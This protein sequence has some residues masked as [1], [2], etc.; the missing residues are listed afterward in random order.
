MKEVNQTQIVPFTT[1]QMYNLVNDIEQYPAFLPWCGGASIVRCSPEEIEATI[2]ISKG[3][4]SQSFTTLNRLTINEKIDMRLVNG[5]F[6]SLEGYWKFT[7][8]SPQSCEISLHLSFEFI[9]Q[10]MSLT[11]GPAFHHIASSMVEAFTQRARQIYT[12]SHA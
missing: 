6:K 12:A 5:P 4:F 1:A 3:L 7:E 11:L 8:L 9:N 10:M 2:K